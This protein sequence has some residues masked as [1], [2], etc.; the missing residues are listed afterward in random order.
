MHK[1]NMKSLIIYIALTL[2]SISISFGYSSTSD[3]IDDINIMI[4]LKKDETDVHKIYSADCAIKYL[5][6]FEDSKHHTLRMAGFAM[7]N[8]LSKTNSKIDTDTMNSLNP[9]KSTEKLERRLF[10]Y[11]IP[12]NVTPIIM[13]KVIHRFAENNPAKLTLRPSL[14]IQAACN[15]AWGKDAWREK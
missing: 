3:L 15:D 8:L 14:F 10:G 2:F 5:I 11:S 4:N 1:N 9:Y 7:I 6:G 12:N 13:G